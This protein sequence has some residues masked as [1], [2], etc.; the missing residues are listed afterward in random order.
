MAR[1][2]LRAVRCR[3]DRAALKAALLSIDLEDWQQLVHRRLRIDGWD[4]VR[5]AIER[6]VNAVLDIL[7]D[8]GAKAT[9]FLLGMT[10]KNHPQLVE[11]VVA[12]GHEPACHGYA[13]TPV[14][15][16]SPDEFRRD[17]EA[18]I[19]VIEDT[20]GRRPVTYRAPAFSINRRT[21]WAYDVLVEAG[22]RYDSSQY[23]SP[24]ISDRFGGIP[25]HPYR[26]Q[27]GSGR[28]LWELPVAVWRLR[29]WTLPIGGGSYWR[30]L[31]RQV[32]LRALRDLTDRNAYPVLYLHPYECD[33][34]ALDA[35]IPA[36]ATPQQRAHAAALR[37]WRNSGRARA[38]TRL[39]EIAQRVPL[40]SYA[41]AYADI[42]R[43]HGTRT[44]ALSQAGFLV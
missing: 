17:L 29:R 14:P 40:L 31:P 4:Q 19:A 41:E 1:G 21:P 28:E 34:E 36:T 37:A 18:A 33:P 10:V 32:L 24:R 13:H 43:D 8:I 12:R 15:R 25:L 38:V 20:C 23:D 39:R 16:Q 30:I 6:Q 35:D 26:L 44:R 42:E 3:Y 2:I 7:D 11:A 5:P 27:L 9:F 22:F